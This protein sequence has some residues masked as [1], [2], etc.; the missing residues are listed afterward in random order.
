LTPQTNVSVTKTDSSLTAVPGTSTTYTIVV[1]NSGPS[2]AASVSVSDSLPAGA[3]SASWSGNGHTNVSGALSDTIASLAPG[4]SVTYTDVVQ[5]GAA[6][7]GNLVNT[8]TVSQANDTTPGN[9]SATDTDSLTPQ[10]DVSVTKT[11]Y[12]TT[13]VPGTS[14]TYKIVV[15]NSG[16]SNAP[17]TLVSDT[18]PVGTTGTW[19]CTATSGATCQ[20]ASGSG[21]IAETDS[22]PK[23]GSVTYTLVVSIPASA[24]GSL[25]NTATVS[26]AND[27][28]TTNNSA[29]DTDTLTPKTD[30]GVTKTGP[31][32][33]QWGDP[34]TYVLT[35]TNTGPSNA[36]GVTLTDALP[37]GFSSATYCIDGPTPP[38]NPAAGTTWTSPLT[39]GPMTAGSTETIRIVTSAPSSLAMTTVSN[40]ASVYGN[41]TDPTPANNTSATVQ[42]SV[43]KRATKLTYTGV[44]PASG[45]YSDPAGLK[46]TLVDATTNDPVNGST[47]TF[48]FP[49]PAAQSMT[50]TTDG[51]GV[52]ATGTTVPDRLNQPAATKTINI[53]ATATSLYA[54]P[55]AITQSYQIKAEDAS[56]YDFNPPSVVVPVAGGTSGAFAITA[57]VAE[58]ADGYASTD[59]TPS[60]GLAKAPVTLAFSPVG[61]GSAP[62][63]CGPTTPAYTAG[64]AGISCP[65][66]SLAVNVYEIDATIGS[67]TGSVPGPGAYF[68]GTGIG[69]VTIMDPSLGFTTGGGWFNYTDPKGITANNAKVNFGFNAK[70]LK[71]G[72]VQGSVLTIFKRANGNYV[73]KSNS[74]GTLA[75]AQIV[76]TNPAHYSA[77]F[78]GKSTY[79]VP[80]TDPQLTPFC[81]DWKCGAY[82]FTVY[83][84]DWAEPGTGKD[85]YWIQVKDPSGAVVAKAT[86][87]PA[88]TGTNVGANNAQLIAGGN[89]QVPQ[90]QG[91]K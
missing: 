74:M 35:V 5:I 37:A 1:S 21:N 45:Q 68:T 17:G 39:I 52:A 88:N 7:T 20:N 15:S 6:A 26:Q 70:V 3:T 72:Q 19:T 8:A 91:G 22:V 2:T 69:V 50:A 67:F 66:S 58:A 49:T 25:S 43:T 85:K 29:T 16:P 89:I 87:N 86:I 47:V 23:S 54:A 28:N 56:V 55:T 24:S 33:V 34:I 73:V 9:N 83:V 62:P 63:N 60:D 59:M 80:I 48:A 12:A 79:S 64:V 18:L 90:P 51:S 31:T 77:T 57:T 4:G 65:V 11:D 32:S 44:T 61:T 13:A 42:T 81:S 38:C 41:E 36:T 78:N 10:T 14:T 40:T 75:V 27:T 76:G 53:T 82:T 84:E 71:S 46:A 30:L